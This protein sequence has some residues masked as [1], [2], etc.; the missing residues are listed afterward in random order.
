MHIYEDTISGGNVVIKLLDQGGGI[1]KG[2]DDDDYDLESLF[3]FAQRETV[4]DRMDEQQT[5]ARKF[6]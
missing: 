5:Y 4:W 6:S 2:S 3:R 1:Q